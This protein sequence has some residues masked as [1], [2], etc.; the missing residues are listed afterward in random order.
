M[1]D[2]KNLLEKISLD[3]EIIIIIPM[4]MEML[5]LINLEVKQEIKEI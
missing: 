5:L 4:L 1:M 2:S 3:Q